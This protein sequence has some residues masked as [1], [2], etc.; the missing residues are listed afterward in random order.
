[1]CFKEEDDRFVS[2]EHIVRDVL[3]VRCQCCQEGMLCK[4]FV[5]RDRMTISPV[6]GE[7]NSLVRICWLV[8][9][10]ASQQHASVSQEW[11]IIRKGRG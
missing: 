5:V 6:K 3:Q 9:C 10:L 2:K 4:E 8:G 11:I 7:G 1:M